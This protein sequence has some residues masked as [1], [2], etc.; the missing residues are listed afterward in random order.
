MRMAPWEMFESITGKELA[1]NS[2]RSFVSARMAPTKT[3]LEESKVRT[4]FREP[5]LKGRSSTNCATCVPAGTT[6]LP[7]PLVVP[8]AAVK[9][10]ER[11]EE[12]TSELQS[13]HDLVCR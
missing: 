9:E 13:H 12:H 11:S 1:M 5:K 10:N 8:S 6:M 7:C 3:G 2:E 4:A